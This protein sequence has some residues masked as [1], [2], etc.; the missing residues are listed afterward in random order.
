[1]ETPQNNPPPTPSRVPLTRDLI[2]RRVPHILAIYAGASWALVEFTA[3]ATDEF[4]LSP[5]WTRVVL[6]TLL[7]ML[8][9]VLMLAWFH[10][11]PGRDRDSLARTEKIGIPANAV[12]CAVLL[13]A[14]FAGEELGSAT[15]SV[16]VETEE[17]T[18]TRETT[19]PEFRKH[20][21]LFPLELGPGLAADELWTAYAV[22]LAIEYDLMP[23]DFFVPVTFERFRWSLIEDYPDLQGIPLALMREV[24]QDYYAG[25]M[26]VGEID[27]VEDRYRVALAV[28]EVDGGN[29]LGDSVFEGSDLLALAD[30]MSGLVRD[31]LRIPV[32]DGVTDSPVRQLLTEDE[33][34]LA[35]FV[36]GVMRLTDLS[37]EIEHLRAAVTLDP[38]FTAAHLQLSWRLTNTDREGEGLASI[39]A[40]MEY[41]SRL[42][43]RARF[44]VRAEYYDWTGEPEKVREIV[45]LWLDL[46]PEDFNALE[47]Q[48]GLRMSEGDWE[49]ALATLAEM[50]RLNPG[51]GSVLRRMARPHEELEQYDSAAA[52]LTRYVERFPDDEVGYIQLADF[53]QRRGEYDEARAQ[54][55]KGLLLHPISTV[56]AYGLVDLDQ[57]T[58]RFDEAR[59]GYERVLDRARTPVEKARALTRM[60]CHHHFRGEMRDAVRAANAW[61]VEA[62]AYTNPEW[63]PDVRFG[64]LFIYLDADRFGEAADLLEEL[65]GRTSP[66]FSDHLAPRAEIHIALETSG[67]EAA[68]EKHDEWVRLLEARGSEGLSR[69]A[70]KEDLGWIQE[71]AGDH[72][73][74]LESY[75]AAIALRSYQVE[76]FTGVGFGNMHLGAGR[77]LRKMG[78]LDEAEA[79]LRES[80]RHFPSLPGAH[81]ELALVLEARGDTAGAVEHLKRALAAWENADENFEPAR[82]ARA[83]LAEL[84]GS[85]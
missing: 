56:L 43:E 68:R 50:Y 10:G 59:A 30:G 7:L 64:D 60:K 8:P 9:S 33:A 19:R 5:L 24:A 15:R 20:T 18:I 69:S 47:T 80:L 65:K 17:G 82:E 34:A 12:L 49:G 71:R 81:L 36:K 78:R 44:E 62:S 39:Q 1:M 22:P 3:F 54:L 52:A 28:H 21:A 40:A 2:H 23:D 16:R 37:T 45:D 58:G 83:K 38:T 32:R 46:H 51:N 66:W 79:E 35:E 29:V 75:R 13:W 25:F 27:R 42:P 76:C 26:T 74:A 57:R 55:E 6:V 53:R 85:V 73:G 67:V 77:A 48:S 4:L 63:L 14:L 72:A 31:A 41:L 61:L 11:K 70:V 84:G